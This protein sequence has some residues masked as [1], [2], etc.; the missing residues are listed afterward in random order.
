MKRFSFAGILPAAL[1]SFAARG[2]GAFLFG[3]VASLPAVAAPPFAPVVV[4]NPV[5][6][7]PATSNRTAGFL[8]CKFTVVDGTRD[9][10]Q[11][12]FLGREEK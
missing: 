10:K 1:L 12:S 4:T 8:Y 7:N 9:T 2:F 11:Y 3:M 6:L 5:S